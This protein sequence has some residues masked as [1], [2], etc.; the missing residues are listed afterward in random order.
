MVRAWTTVLL[1][2]T[3]SACTA[4]VP[5][6]PQN[7]AADKGPQLQQH[8]TAE[9]EKA[10]LD[11]ERLVN[12]TVQ[13]DIAVHTR[14][15]AIATEV[16]PDAVTVLD[17]K[18]PVKLDSFQVMHAGDE[19]QRVVLLFDPANLPSDDLSSV[20]R[21]VS[22]ALLHNDGKLP[23]PTAIAVMS[24]QGP[25][26]SAYTKDG[27]ALAASFEQSAN[28]PAH[29]P[30]GLG[31]DGG[32]GG[33]GMRGGRGGGGG[34]SG[35]DLM[36]IQRFV[37]DSIAFKGRTAII[38]LGQGWPL[39]YGPELQLTDAQ[40][41][42]WLRQAEGLVT[43]LRRARMTIYM[44]NPI[45]T[46]RF[47]ADSM[48]YLGFVKGP[49]SL[50]EG[51]PAFV[52]LQILAIHSGGWVRMSSEISK[53]MDDVYAEMGLYYHASF[54]AQPTAKPDTLH[55]IDYKTATKDIN[56]RG[57]DVYWVNPDPEAAPSR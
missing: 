3:I 20:K 56:A 24:P 36:A 47:N 17:D 12:R 33:G 43:M 31:G 4:Q 51:A 14:S 48:A 41:L 42:A 15:G 10:E 44:V 25:R 38:W 5:A 40:R 27:K 37:G 18:R 32:S 13:L 53:V 34:T 28:A 46:D 1:M 26:V 16:K 39:A 11:A 57:I 45:D 21:A 19:P 7:T 50:A 55:S 30:G 6:V 49:K 35:R 2:G 54:S 22:A 29:T 52:G 23:L 9:Q 8:M